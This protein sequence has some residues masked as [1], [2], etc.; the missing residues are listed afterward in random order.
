MSPACGG[1]G[2][3]LKRGEGGQQRE[4][5]CMPATAPVTVIACG[6]VTGSA[7]TVPA[8][9]GPPRR[10]P[11]AAAIVRMGPLKCAVTLRACCV[12]A[13]PVNGSQQK[14]T[15]VA[16]R[17]QDVS[18]KR[19]SLQLHQLD[20]AAR[21]TRGGRRQRAAPFGLLKVGSRPLAAC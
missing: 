11:D 2:G 15:H 16:A 13:F 10:L 14:A 19:G 18:W 9:V 20:A 17:G 8:L 1:A 6:L 21:P 5:G 7:E 12:Q 3:A 4:P